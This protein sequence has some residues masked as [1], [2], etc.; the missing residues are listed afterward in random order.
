M[1]P[2]SELHDADFDDRLERID[3]FWEPIFGLRPLTLPIAY[4]DA[5]D[6][7][8]VARLRRQER[9]ALAEAY[10]Q[11]HGAVRGLARRV[12]GDDAA[13]EDLVQEVFVALPRA[14]LGFEGRSQLRTFL[15]SMVINHAKHHVRAAARRRALADRYGHT[16]R[17]AMVD[18]ARV[19]EE[20]E[21]AWLLTRALDELPLEQRAAFVLLELE[22]RS[23]SD[24]AE[25][26]GVPEATMRTRL[27]HA[28]RKLRERLEEWGAR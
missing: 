13:A 15:L 20:R 7:S 5:V 14:I 4:L 25:I 23:A 12:V 19:V 3:V 9:A 1:A 22:D 26:A 6:E 27:Y 16:K 2:S 11:F 28:K 21:L 18:G 17:D 24:A 8:L 10:D